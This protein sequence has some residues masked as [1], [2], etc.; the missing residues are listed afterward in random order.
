ME[1]VRGW[2]MKR[3]EV[4]LSIILLITLLL[5]NGCG[6]ERVTEGAIEFTV[7][8]G[9]TYKI[10]SEMYPEV[11]DP[12]DV[13][14]IIYFYPE[15]EDQYFDFAIWYPYESISENPFIE[16]QDTWEKNGHEYIYCTF[17]EEKV[18]EANLK[19][20]QKVN[21]VPEYNI[22][23]TDIG[24]SVYSLEEPTSAFRTLAESIDYK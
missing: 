15:G 14:D 7:P 1:L 18:I 24:I 3:L 22:L 6:E 13:G 4:V 10:L 2:K 5:I 8:D 21:M 20:G 9:Y 17:D 19:F 11:N 12:S 16:I 23:I